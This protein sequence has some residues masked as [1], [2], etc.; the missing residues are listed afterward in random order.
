[1]RTL[2]KNGKL[3]DGSGAAPMQGDIL[4]EDDRIVKLGAAHDR[5]HRGPFRHP[6]ARL[7][8]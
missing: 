8:A 5:R 4:I 2:L 7:S 3:Y 6:Q 1:M